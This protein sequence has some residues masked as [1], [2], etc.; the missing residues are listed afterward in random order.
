MAMTTE[1]RSIAELFSDALHQSTKLIRTELELARAEV[2]AKASEAA[3]GIAFLAGGALVM[4]AALVLLLFA[5]AV[6]LVELGVPDPVAYLVAGVVGA[7]LSVMLGWTGMNRLKP[8]NL[9]PE[10]TLKQFQRD[11]A[12]IRE[13]MK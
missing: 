4:I 1:T 2:A 3:M 11:A 8:G 7:L 12:V 6:W 5:L 9:A 13:Q 10:R